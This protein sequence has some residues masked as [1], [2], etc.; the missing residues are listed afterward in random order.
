MEEESNMCETCKKIFFNKYNLKRHVEA[1]LCQKKKDAKTC[2]ICNKIFANKQYLQKHLQTPKHINNVKKTKIIRGNNNATISSFNNNTGIIYNNSNNININ[3]FPHLE[4]T[5]DCLSEEEKI[6]ILK[7]CY[8]AVPELI[9]KVNFN[10]KIPQN[11]NVYL[12]GKQSKDGHIFDG[13]KW[14]A[15]ETNNIINDMIDKNVDDIDSL[16]W[17]YKE[18]ILKNVAEKIEDMIEKLEYDSDH[19]NPDKNKKKFKK[20]IKDEIRLILYNNQDLPKQT[21]EINEKK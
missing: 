2:N 17:V 15:K 7:K 1:S 21:K 10:K 18:K 6:K 3:I 13:K 12:T 20:K 19:D 8:N 5:L 16:L 11:H 4:E 9:K 14:I